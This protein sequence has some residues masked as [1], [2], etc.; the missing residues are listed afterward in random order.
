MLDLD[1]TPDEQPWLDCAVR[2]SAAAKRAAAPLYGTAEGRVALSRGAGGD[3]T[4]EIDR[5]CESAMI[6]VLEKE[7]PAPW[8]LVSE[9]LGIVGPEDAPWRV[10]IDPLDGSLNAKHGLEP[11]GSSIAVAQGPTLADVTVGY[12]ED[13]TRPRC[14]AAVKGAGLVAAG[15]PPPGGAATAAGASGAAGITSAGAATGATAAPPATL[16]LRRFDSDLVEL[17]FLEAGTPD[18]HSFDY[19]DLGAVGTLGQKGDMR[20]RQIGSLALSLCLVAVG[21]ADVLIARVRSRSVDVAAGLLILAEAGGGAVALTPEDLMAQP[22][23]LEKRSAFVAWR[24]GLD[25]SEMVSRSS[26]LRKTLLGL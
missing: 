23:D 11:F 8:S 1:M 6:E 3:R 9:E 25:E 21:V 2:M 16:D 18:R 15:G 7:A 12:I 14:F 10:V 4:L 19:H 5:A 24:A 22:L 26:E 20:I 13:Y 17:V